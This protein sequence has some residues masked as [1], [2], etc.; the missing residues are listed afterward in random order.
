MKK[1]IAG[2]VL[3]FSLFLPSFSAFASVY[4]SG[5]TKANGTYVQGYYR[6]DPNGTVTD[7]YSYPGNTN[8]YTGVTAGGNQSTTYSAYYS[9]IDTPAYKKLQDQYN[10]QCNSVATITS[11]VCS[12][13]NSKMVNIAITQHLETFD[14]TTNSYSDTHGCDQGLVFDSYRDN[15]QTPEI[16]KK[17]SAPV[18]TSQETSL[19]QQINLLLAIVAQLQAQILALQTH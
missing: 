1:L 4:V 12:Q 7:N 18:P 2:L 5:Y 6:S 15:C 14:S 16:L 19:A 8:P 11:D 17:D 3:G 13:L 10:V 9:G